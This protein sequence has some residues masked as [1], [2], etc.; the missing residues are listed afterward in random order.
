MDACPIGPRLSTS[1]HSRGL[2]Q[3]EQGSP[4]SQW[5]F[6]EN[7]R[8]QKQPHPAKLQVHDLALILPASPLPADNLWAPRGKQGSRRLCCVGL[9]PLH[10]HSLLEGHITVPSSF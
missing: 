8:A 6:Q 10:L 9:K 2:V 4:L 1:S 3:Q 7:W 5:P